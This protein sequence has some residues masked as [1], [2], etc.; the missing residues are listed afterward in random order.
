MAEEKAKSAG[1]I[2][3]KVYLVCLRLSVVE[4]SLPNVIILAARLN[5]RA[6]QVIADARPGAFIQKIWATK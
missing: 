5:R 4:P 1:R 2:P 6:A 3:I